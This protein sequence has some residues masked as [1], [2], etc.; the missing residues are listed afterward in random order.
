MLFPPQLAQ[1]GGLGH[2]ASAAAPTPAAGKTPA[3]TAGE[4][5]AIE[6]AMGKKGT[7]VEAPATHATPLP[8]NDLKVIIK[9]EAVPIPFGLAAGWP[10]SARW[11][12]SRRC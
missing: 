11:T 8:R 10:S 12:A 3:L 4:I 6:A 5:A 1:D 2:H 9:G 7:Y